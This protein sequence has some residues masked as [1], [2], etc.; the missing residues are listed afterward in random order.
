MFKQKIIIDGTMFL[1][2]VV[3]YVFCGDIFLLFVMQNNY[4]ATEL[5]L[6]INVTESSARKRIKKNPTGEIPDGIFN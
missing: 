4:C 2:L 5:T 3:A 6:K 1:R